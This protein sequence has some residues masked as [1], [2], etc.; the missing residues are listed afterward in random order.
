MNIIDNLRLLVD[1]KF[2]APKKLKEVYYLHNTICFSLF[3]ACTY[4]FSS[5]TAGQ[6]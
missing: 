1:D 5:W 3:A 6:W 4:V 2:I